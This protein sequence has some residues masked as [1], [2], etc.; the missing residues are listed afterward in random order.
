M[1]S[2]RAVHVTFPKDSVFLDARQPAKASVMVKLRPGARLSPANVLAVCHLVASAVE[3]LGPEAVSVL[4][5]NGKP[6]E[7]AAQGFHQRGRRAFRG[8]AGLPPPDRE[9]LWPRS[10][11][12]WTRCWAARSSARGDVRVRLHGGEQSEETYD[13]TRSVMVSAQK[14]EDVSGTN[15]AFR[16]PRHGFQSATADLAAGVLRSRHHARTENI[17]YQSSR[18]VRRHAFCRRER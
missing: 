4:D 17:A 15:L 6:A 3:G 8:G 2:R 12:R 18:L 16:S 11:R 10:P 13:P 14:T 7:P 9:D 1:S 5:M